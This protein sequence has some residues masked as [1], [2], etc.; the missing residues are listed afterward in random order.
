M[1][2]R[3]KRHFTPSDAENM[4]KD[5]RAFHHLVRTWAGQVQPGTTIYALIEVLNGDLIVADGVLNATIH[6]QA[7]EWPLGRAGLP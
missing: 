7:Y 3:T 4:Q 5:I 2:Q 6:Q 1:V